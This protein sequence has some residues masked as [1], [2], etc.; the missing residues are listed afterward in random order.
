MFRSTSGT[1]FA[2][3][4]AAVWTA[5]APVWAILSLAAALLAPARAH[6]DERA[7]MLR[8]GLGVAAL[9]GPDRASSVGSLGG[10]IPV[11]EAMGIE[12]IGALGLDPEAQ[13]GRMWIGLSAGVRVD[14][15]LEAWRPYIAA[16]VAHLHDA[17]LEAWSRHFGETLAGDPAYGLGHLTA[18]GGG[19]GVNWALPNT[20][21]RL[22]LGAEVE[23]LGL[24]H[25]HAH[26][27]RS[28]DAWIGGSLN[29]GWQFL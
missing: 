17:P 26:H 13:V 3:A 16:R 9:A 2:R 5:T 4:P 18:L 24:V 7:F 22:W 20:E 19:L 1:P 23:V 11:G 6:A 27:G 28:P 15:P 14:L 25:G 12:I 21:R 10:L 8:V 29:A